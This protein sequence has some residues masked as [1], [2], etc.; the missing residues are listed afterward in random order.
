MK[1]LEEPPYLTVG[2][3]VSAKYRG[4]FCEAKIKTA[5]RLVK[6]KVT[7]KSDLSTAEVNDESIK[8]PL[9][10]GAIVEVKN[11]D[12]VHQEAT[13]NKLTD[14]S[15][16]T[17]VFDDGDE[18]TLRRSSLCLKGARHFAE[19]ETLDRLPLTN[20][21]HFGTPVIGKK[22]NRGRRSNP[23]QEEDSSSSSSEE[24]ES[25][26]RQ[27]EDLFGKV[28]CVEGV[29]MGDKK[30]T[31]WY[32]AL[33]T[34]PDCHDDITIKKESLFV[35]SF[36]DGK[37]YMVLRK[38]VREID[39]NCPPKADA[40]LKPA[41]DAA[42]EFQQ[43][44]VIPGTWKTEVKEES[45]GSEVEDDDEEEEQE[46]DASGEE[47]EE[48][49]EPYPEERENFLQQLYKFMEDRRTPINKRPVL[50]YRNLNLFKL[51]RLVN[52]LGGF[53]NIESGAV[54]KQIYQNLGIP[55]LNSAAGYNVKCA[56]RKY[57]YGF[58]EYCT[59]TAITFKMDLPLKQAPKGEVMCVGEGGNT[60]TTFTS[61]EEEKDHGNGDPISKQF[62]VCK[63]EKLELDPNK[64][65]GTTSKAEEKDSNG[66]NNKDEEEEEEEE[67]EAEDEEDS[68]P[69]T[70]DADEGSSTFHLS[71]KQEHD[72]DRESKDNSGD[73]NS[74]EGE[75]GEEF[76]CYPPGMKVQVRYGRGRSL[77]TYEATV[78]EA[79]VE[80]GE[81][82]YLVHY[83]GWN[84]RYDE[85]IKADK[86][87]RPANKNVPKIKHRKK[88][89]NKSERE[90]DR[91]E[92]LSDREVL[93]PPLN[94]NRVPRSKCDLSQ[95]VFSKLD[96]GKDQ[97]TQQQSPAK[98]IEITSILNASEL[99][100][101]E[102]DHE[103]D[104]E[105]NIQ[106]NN[107]CRDLKGSSELQ[108][109][110][111]RSTS[112]TPPN[113]SKLFAV[114]G[115]NQEIISGELG[116]RKLDFIGEGGTRKRKSEGGADRT[117]KN[118]SKAKRATRSSDWLPA[119]TS[120]KL[121]ERSAGAM[122]ERGASSSNSSD[123]EGGA[124]SGSQAECSERAHPKTKGSPSK[125]YNGT[126][127]KSKSSRQAGFWDI[128]EKRAKL[129]GNGEDKPAVRA[130]GQKDVW[131][132][133]QAQWPKKTLKE[134]F[135]DS[136]TEAANSPPPPAPSSLEDT[137]VD[138]EAGPEDDA[139]E[140]HID[141]NKLQEF[142]SSG[143]NS[144]LNTPPTTPESPSGRGSA[145][146]DSGQA[147][148]PSPL[149]PPTPPGLL[150]VSS[151]ANVLPGLAQEEVACR[152]SESDCSTVEVDSLGGELP[153]LPQ[154][155]G[156]GSPPKVFDAPLSSNSSSNC[157][158]EMS[159]SSQHEIEQKSKASVS[160]KR[161]KESQTCGISKKHKPN[162]KSLGVPPK[163]NRKTANSSDSEDQSFVEGCAK[164]APTKNDTSDIKVAVSPKC[165]G[166]SP[167]SSHKYHKQGD[168]EHSQHREH[169]GR[170]PRVYKWS[171]QMSDLEKMSSLERISFL[172]DKL[173]DIRNH[174]LSL[175]SEVAS[176]D[177]RRKRMKK[178]ELE[179]TVAASSSSSSS[180]P[181]SSSLTAAVMLTLAD[182]PVS[183]SSSSSSSSSQNSGVSVE[184]R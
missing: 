172:Q 155:G 174:Y 150:P 176:I 122:E 132:S 54:W 128:P 53:D 27:N 83:C 70:G 140:E 48:E 63:E 38:D 26:Q 94:N 90:R 75:E 51:Y 81:V 183:S 6:A 97:G 91:L 133:I 138:Q 50:G 14:A 74:Q 144:V 77:K 178:K 181:S 114:S 1:T 61:Q 45:S 8:G 92:R 80:G 143:S 98:S 123:D 153:D 36:K 116:K 5:K 101:E 35:R 31:T 108:K 64:S 28:V 107:V 126:K 68:S 125:K 167:P 56:Y 9:K 184:C 85:W 110:S 17:V 93:C 59:S 16:Y 66:N 99:S 127:D 57:L 20:P 136:D 24:E 95:D 67:E 18:K 4:A 55:V 149:A 161:Q 100:S 145:L 84:I 179:S 173:Q 109:S 89:K 157:S 102:S 73:D 111:E 96:Q 58:E 106:D 82:L 166:R 180:S 124:G 78:K 47:E 148:Q 170:S 46:E 139:S 177:R 171:F 163:K 182:Q 165:R 175:K 112:C 69:K 86:I 113:E 134:L 7:F 129:S 154:V 52:K 130:K 72:E 105:R 12:G 44:L 23:I 34:S 137:S 29:A 117:L 168:A 88:I 120:R 2:T 152:R 160:Q 19:S 40:A 10:V 147:P 87:V 43:Q 15:I 156:P 60:T 49:V 62:V 119:G 39:T 104:G 79:D 169:H 33:V 135:S 13:I 159:S 151:S 76:E 3:D 141:H 42:L 131:S 121:E 65:D 158:L 164:P 118:Q 30:K 22:G 115:K 25:D 32:P 41:L 11:Q 21:E 37:F 142:P 103:G 71:I 162:R 146:E